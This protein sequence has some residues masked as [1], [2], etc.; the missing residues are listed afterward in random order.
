[1][2]YLGTLTDELM[3]VAGPG[4]ARPQLRLGVAPLSLGIDTALP[5]GL[6]VTELVQNA[7]KYAFP[8]GRRGTITVSLG[9]EVEG[10]LSLVVMDDGVGLPAVPDGRVAL[11]QRPQPTPGGR[12][13]RPPSRHS[14]RYQ[15]PEG[16]W[17]GPAL[18]FQAYAHIDRRA[19][20]QWY[21][22]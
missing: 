9:R 16:A 15:W 7:L 22:R 21:R 1:M 2:A 6:I 18:T 4:G 13:R 3:R 11:A 17:A 12:R 19:V 14:N 8:N 5:C 20:S 10:T